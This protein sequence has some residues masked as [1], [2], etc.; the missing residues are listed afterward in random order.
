MATLPSP[1]TRRGARLEIIPFIDIMF[2]LLAT[3]MM[4]SLAM[5]QNEGINLTLPTAATAIPAEELPEQSTVS[6]TAEGEIFLNREPVS[7]EALAPFFRQLYAKDPESRVIVQ[8]DYECD[9]GVVV[10]V[11]DTARESGLTRLILR[12]RKSD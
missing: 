2:F 1:R 4:A 11:F 8:G 9:Y 12:T 10:E 3:F 5:V 7:R 6:V